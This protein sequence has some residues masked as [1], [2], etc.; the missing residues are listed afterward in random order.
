MSEDNGITSHPRVTSTS[1][2]SLNYTMK[3]QNQK[4]SAGTEHE[5][6]LGIIK[7]DNDDSYSHMYQKIFWTLHTY[8]FCMVS[9]NI[10]TIGS[11]IIL[12]FA[13][14][15][16]WSL[17]GWGICPI[18]WQSKG[19]LRCVLLVKLYST[20]PV[21]MYMLKVRKK[22]PTLEHKFCMKMTLIQSLAPYVVPQHHWGV[23]HEP[24][25]KSM[26]QSTV[27][28]VPQKKKKKN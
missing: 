3:A 17:K 20:L 21:F 5:K 18:K 15:E 13:S 4:L 1:L 12:I 7:K 14:K 27:M 25:T 10:C 24:T 19:K 23:N 6:R 8:K 26:L 9:P 11:I 2:G 28:C 16:S 22:E